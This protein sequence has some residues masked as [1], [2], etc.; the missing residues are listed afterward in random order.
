MAAMAWIFSKLGG[1]VVVAG[2]VLATIEDVLKAELE[3]LGKG[4]KKELVWLVLMVV[5]VVVD[6]VYDGNTALGCKG[7]SGMNGSVDE[8]AV[9]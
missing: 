8:L 3:G 2:I 4:D 7:S 5:V 1:T 6:L 9:Y